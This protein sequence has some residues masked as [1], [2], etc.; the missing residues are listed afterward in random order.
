[1]EQFSHDKVNRYLGKAEMRP[2]HLW[3]KVKPLLEQ[4][5]QGYILFDDSTIDKNY[6]TRIDLVRRQWSGNAK[7]VIRGIGFVSCVYVQP[8]SGKFLVIDYRIFD[9]DRDG[10]SKIDHVVDMFNSAIKRG[11]LFGTV[12]MD[13]W[14]ASKNLF[15]LFE[16]H[17]KRYYCPLKV[18][19]Q[20]D[21]SGGKTPYQRVDQLEWSEEDLLAGKQVKMRGMPK[22]HKV[23]LF[24]VE[25]STHRTEYVVTNDTTQDSA[26]GARKECAVRWKIEESYRDLKQFVG[27]EK[28]QCRKGRIQRNHIH[29]AVLVWT[30]FKQRSY[31]CG[32]SVKQLK[33]G[34]LEDYLIQQLKNPSISMRGA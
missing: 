3:E 29:C 5:E 33:E 32:K 19:R 11:L 9:P 31:Q 10:K 24:R 26:Q 23:Q 4:D 13:S 25:V 1:M 30:R 12:L 27:I 21:D 17:H 18:N 20:V 34:L 22:N 7:K 8:A 28:C 14:Y 2:R 15:L 16:Q 6:S